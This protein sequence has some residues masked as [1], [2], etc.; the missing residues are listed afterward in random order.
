MTRNWHKVLGYQAIL[1]AAMLA[2]RAYAD[3]GAQKNSDKPASLDS[4][5]KEQLDRIE[6]KLGSI[7]TL[8]SDVGGVK[9][10]IELMRQANTQDF[11]AFHKRVTEL[12]KRL[13]AFESHLNQTPTRVANFPPPNGTAT[14]PPA[15]HIRLLNSYPRPAT[16]I[17]NGLSHRLNPYEA[18]SID[19]AP[20]TFTS[21][22]LVDGYGSVQP[23]MS[24][25]I[26]ANE[27]RTIEVYMR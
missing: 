21:E 25:P 11:E 5:I 27:S 13:A 14:P 7:D 4:K 10:E 20:G 23:M 9:K 22:V 17:L 16:V 26:A 1:A 15:S 6:N 12:E 2:P 24:K 8:K 19:V 18:R 3:D